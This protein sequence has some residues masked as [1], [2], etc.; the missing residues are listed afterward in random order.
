MHIVH[1]EI[2]THMRGT[3][4]DKCHVLPAR[5]VRRWI[6]VKV[7]SFVFVYV[8]MCMSV[9]E[10]MCICMN[11]CT[12]VHVDR[13]ER[14]WVNCVCEWIEGYAPL[15]ITLM[16]DPLVLYSPIWGM[17]SNRGAHSYTNLEKNRW[18]DDCHNCRIKKLLH[19]LEDFTLR[20]MME[21]LDLNFDFQ[22]KSCVDM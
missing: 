7:Y 2:V 17:N 19:R 10:N 15:C 16:Y 22:T 1:L 6:R 9:S 8:Q 14:V 13:Y 4:I 12:C 21:F 18:K 20:V 11:T 3:G 5:E